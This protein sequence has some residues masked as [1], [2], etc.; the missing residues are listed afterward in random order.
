MSDQ[1]EPIIRDANGYDYAKGVPSLVR[2]HQKVLNERWPLHDGTTPHARGIN[3]ARH[4]DGTPW[5]IDVH[6]R[7]ELEHDG[8]VVLPGRAERWTRT[9][10]Y[11][12]VEDQRVPWQKVWVR[13]EDVRR[14]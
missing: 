3:D 6:V 5:T 12:V 7:I 8:E 11:V 1:S 4:A 2:A 14:R 9:H 13:A 10:V